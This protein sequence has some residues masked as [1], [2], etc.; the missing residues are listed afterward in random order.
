M[1][2]RRETI[3]VVQGQSQSDADHRSGERGPQSPTLPGSDPY[4]GE[5]DDRHPEGNNEGGHGY[6]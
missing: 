4:P 1:T 2:E 3:Y 6:L 5:R